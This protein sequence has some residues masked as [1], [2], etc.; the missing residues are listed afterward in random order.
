MDTS[1]LRQ[2]MEGAS[3]EI[4]HAKKKD[5]CENGSIHMSSPAVDSRIGMEPHEP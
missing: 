2:V 5:G 4:V 1:G 3:I